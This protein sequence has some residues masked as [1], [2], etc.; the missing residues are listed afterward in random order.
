MAEPLAARMRPRA[1]D[2]V[3]GQR[4]LIGEGKP[5]TELVRTGHLPSVI[6]WG[7]AGTG[8]TTL[9]FLLAGDAELVQLSAV[10]SGVGDARK[11]MAKARDSMLSTVLFVDEVHRWSKAQQDV[12]LPAVEDGTITL[13]G[14]TTENPYFSLVSPLLSR[15]L[16]MRL[17]PLDVEDLVALVERAWSRRWPRRRQPGATGLIALWPRTWCRRR[18]FTTGISTTTSSRPSSRACE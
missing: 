2:E 8:K 14:A 5:L 16:L 3:V 17:E 7:P 13:I 6:L 9:A 15:C 11:V 1:F 18:S 10:S 4:H 12:L